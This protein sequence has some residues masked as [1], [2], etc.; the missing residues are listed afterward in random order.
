TIRLGGGPGMVVLGGPQSASSNG[1]AAASARTVGVLAAAD[2][3]NG[4]LSASS[5]PSVVTS[6]RV[7]RADGESRCGVDTMPS[8]G[9]VAPLKETFPGCI[10]GGLPAMIARQHTAGDAQLLIAGWSEE[11]VWS[12]ASPSSPTGWRARPRGWRH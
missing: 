1:N 11:A 12:T 3:A 7:Q 8:G 5:R 6:V 10:G 4:A 2:D 9:E